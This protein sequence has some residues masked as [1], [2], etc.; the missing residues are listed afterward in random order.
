MNW[1][2]RENRF[3]LAL[4]IALVFALVLWWTGRI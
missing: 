3:L 2:R 4:A 1:R